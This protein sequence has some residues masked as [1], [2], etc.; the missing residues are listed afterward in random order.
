MLLA[1]IC[2]LASC[3]SAQSE[4]ESKFFNG[5][6]LTKAQKVLISIP[7][8]SKRF[9]TTDPHAPTQILEDSVWTD[10]CRL[11]EE[12]YTTIGASEYEKGYQ[13]ES[14]RC[15]ALPGPWTSTFVDYE[16]H[17]KT[18]SVP[19]LLRPN[20]AYSKKKQSKYLTRLN[21]YLAYDSTDPIVLLVEL[22]ENPVP[23]DVDLG[24]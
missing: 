17:G 1:C 6:S 11:S 18:V 15:T 14:L 12:T 19:A 5:K 9:V 7:D 10:P 20:T 2:G 16:S 21:V 22:E 24:L 4:A 8:H 13:V 23:G 3:H